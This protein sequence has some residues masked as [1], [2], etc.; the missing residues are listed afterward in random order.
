MFRNNVVYR[1]GYR[2]PAAHDSQGLRSGRRYDWLASWH[3][4]HHWAA[5]DG[6]SRLQADFIKM[7]ST[8]MRLVIWRSV[9]LFL[10]LEQGVGL[11]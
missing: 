11:I 6:G 9:F 4:A 7:A 1:I 2:Q 10:G 3:V 8:F 5:D